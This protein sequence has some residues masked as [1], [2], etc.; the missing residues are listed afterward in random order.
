MYGGL[1][2]TGLEVNKSM[3]QVKNNTFERIEQ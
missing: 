1:I 3:A 2:D